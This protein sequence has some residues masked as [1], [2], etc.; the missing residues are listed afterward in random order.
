MTSMIQILMYLLQNHLDKEKRINVAHQALIHKQLRDVGFDQTDIERAFDWLNGLDRSEPPLT[1]T[2]EI[3]PLR[4]YNAE[5]NERLNIEC[6]GFLLF[7]EQKGILTP[8]SR[9]LVIDRLLAL[10]TDDI[11]ITEAKW[12]TMV[13][14]FN[15]P[16]KEAALA[17][18]ER[19]VMGQE[20]GSLH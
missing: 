14:L 8:S 19:L 20:L 16:E 4:V 1:Y 10:D 18:M 15:Q 2:T 17:C 11:S 9:E 12:V 13:V 5:E 6:R 3:A 7:L